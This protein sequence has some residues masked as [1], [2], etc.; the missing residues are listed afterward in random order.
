ML[1][2][3]CLC[4]QVRYQIR[5]E[6]RLMYYC[7]CGACRR[8]TGSSFA[9]NLLVLADDFAVV[10]GRE[11]LASFESSPDKH[12]YFCSGCGSPI[13]SQA[14]ATR[15][16]VSVRAGTLE[17]DPGLRPSV[18]AHVASKAPWC[19]IRDGLRQAPGD[20]A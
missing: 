7:H 19:E 3:S 18:H 2:G 11:R 17:G 10:A 12:R 15:A 1:R 8:A 5:G 6:P 9:S 13:Y 20:L 16:I 4:G 14:K